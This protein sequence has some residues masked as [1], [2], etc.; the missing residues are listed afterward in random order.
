METLLFVAERGDERFEVV[1]GGGE[2]VY[3]LRY[4][5]GQ[6]THDYLQNDIPMA[7][8]CAE[9]EWGSRPQTGVLHFRARRPY[10]RSTPR[11]TI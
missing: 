4:F 11:A 10:G 9:D 3:V 2:G 5:G 8:G 6:S 1:A 7:Y